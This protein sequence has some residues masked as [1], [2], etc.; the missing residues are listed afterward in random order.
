[1]DTGLASLR[2]KM[3][4][5]STDGGE[6]VFVCGATNSRGASWGPDGNIVAALDTASG[7]SLVPAE[8]GKPLALTKLGFGESTHR[9][10][11]FLPEGRTV[12]FTVSATYANYDEAGIAV[13]SLKDRQPKTVLEHA[14]MY[15]GY[16]STGHL[17]YVTKGTLVAARLIPE[18]FAASGANQTDR[19]SDQ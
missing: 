6:P 2:K 1:M 7:L 14:G 15:P 19:G 17:V 4:K 10:P 11:Q 16:L 12:L 9:W 8:G 5:V 3:K 18:R 13:V